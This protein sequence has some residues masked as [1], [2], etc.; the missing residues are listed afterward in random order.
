MLPGAWWNW[1]LLIAGLS[2]LLY[3]VWPVL[4]NCLQR[5]QEPPNPSV[6]FIGACAIIDTYVG[7]AMQDK[8]PSINIVVRND[9]ISRF[10]KTTGAMLGEGQY[11]RQLLHQWL[12]SNAARFLVD[13]RNE[14]L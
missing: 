2:L 7:P 3:A 8:S 5:K 14:M 11:N 9:L 6:D 4:L 12:H 13:H 1:L 10:E